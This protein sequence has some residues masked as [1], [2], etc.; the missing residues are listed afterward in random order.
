MR[1]RHVRRRTDADTWRISTAACDWCRALE[2]TQGANQPH[3]AGLAPIARPARVPFAQATGALRSI[4]GAHRGLPSPGDAGE[5][6]LLRGEISAVGDFLA[7]ARLAH[8]RRRPRRRIAEP[9]AERRAEP[10]SPLVP[11]PPPA[12]PPP[13]PTPPPCAVARE[14]PKSPQAASN[15]RGGRGVVRAG[16][17]RAGGRGERE[18]LADLLAD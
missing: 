4:V 14:P 11:V 7:A 10:S 2:H 5:H 8:E 13:A 12:P 15:G 17:V 6:D 1:R 3:R 9:S 16:R 18:S